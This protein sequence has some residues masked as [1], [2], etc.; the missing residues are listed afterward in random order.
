MLN[1]IASDLSYLVLQARRERGELGTGGLDLNHQRLHKVSGYRQFIPD[2]DDRGDSCQSN[3]R[4]TAAVTSG[5][6]SDTE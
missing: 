2:V 1:T 3:P 4:G 6:E 5:N